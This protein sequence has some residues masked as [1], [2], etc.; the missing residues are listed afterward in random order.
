VFNGRRL[1]LMSHPGNEEL[2]ENL[3]DHHYNILINSGWNKN[4]WETVSEARER[5]ANEW[6]E[7]D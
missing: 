2:K 1:Y 5:A 6:A 4:A 7:Q 3:F